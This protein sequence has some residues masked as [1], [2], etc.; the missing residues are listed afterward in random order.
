MLLDA[1]SLPLVHGTAKDAYHF[2]AA[3][4]LTQV[5]RWRNADGHRRCAFVGDYVVNVGGEYRRY[6]P[7]TFAA[8]FVAV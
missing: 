5:T 7:T 4:P 2:T 1:A 6:D 3:G 8:M